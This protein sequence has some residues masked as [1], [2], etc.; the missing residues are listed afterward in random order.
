MPGQ[1]TLSASRA[2]SRQVPVVAWRAGAV[3]GGIV[4]G[5][6]LA[7]L[8]ATFGVLVALAIPILIAVVV[9]G[10]RRPVWGLGAFLVAMPLSRE[11]VAGVNVVLAGA[12]V[13]STLVM[14]LRLL[15]GERMLSFPPLFG[16]LVVLWSLALAAAVLG[17]DP[18]TSLEL[19]VLLAA[20]LLLTA[21]VAV[22]TEH[23]ADLRLATWLFLG[24]AGVM[25][26]TALADA[27]QAQSV[28]G[29]TLVEGR[30][31][32]SFAQP[33]ELGTFAGLTLL[34]S[35]SWLLASTSRGRV[36]AGVIALPAAAALIASLSRGAWI[37]VVVGVMALVVL[38]PRRRGIV[39]GGL[40]G[41]TIALTMAFVF[42]PQSDQ[43]EVVRSRIESFADPTGNPYDD[44]PAIYREGVRQVQT[45]PLTGFGMG[46]F[47]EE[48]QRQLENGVSEA[49]THAH[50]TLLTVA[51]ETGLVTTT[52]LAVFTLVAAIRTRRR[53]LALADRAARGVGEFGDQIR[54]AVLVGAG[55]G[56]AL[57]V[58]QGL[59]D[60]SLRNPTLHFVTFFLI[61]LLLSAGNNPGNNQGKNLTL[62]GR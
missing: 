36:F 55:S 56:L 12:I 5:W 54:L 11:H 8:A 18:G 24:V 38:L 30:S 49:P 41:I 40:A 48:A 59:V 25:C 33:N 2:A 26:L 10:I 6:V 32:G 53:T 13:A 34:V 37:G 39:A 4:A 58:G 31:Q 27:G 16:W 57:I 35:A 17:I 20:G 61:G 19:V 52:L 1:Q 60:F 62:S 23:P 47:A 14:G 9:L 15:R 51:A 50:N 28:Y 3:V 7:G 29:G 21:T 42:V 46:T 45:R 43:L 44:R 22:S